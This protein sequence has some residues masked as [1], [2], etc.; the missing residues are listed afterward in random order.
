MHTNNFKSKLLPECKES[1][2]QFA[3][4]VEAFSLSPK[5]EDDLDFTEDMLNF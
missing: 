2:S 4:E 1:P 5:S 3:N